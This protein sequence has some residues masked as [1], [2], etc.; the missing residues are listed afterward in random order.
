MSRPDLKHLLRSTSPIPSLRTGPVR[1][2][3][4]LRTK[5]PDKQLLDRLA[6]RG[7]S[8]ESVVQSTIIGSIDA[9]KVA[10]LKDEPSVAEV[11]LS[12]P[13]NRHRS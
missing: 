4:G 12:V 10:D 1:V 7:L 3:V 6:D 13:L 5:A 8:I 9:E 2:L 11:E